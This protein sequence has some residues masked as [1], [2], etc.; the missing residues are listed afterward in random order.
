MFISHAEKSESRS[1]FVLGKGDSTFAVEVV[2]TFEDTVTTDG[3]VIYRR[4]T[5]I[6]IEGDLPSDIKK[7]V[8]AS[9]RRG[10]YAEAEQWLRDYTEVMA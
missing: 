5:A 2:R 3:V 6:R 9:L 4:M 1:A 8:E 10:A 7:V